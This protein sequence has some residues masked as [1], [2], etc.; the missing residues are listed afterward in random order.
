MSLLGLSWPRRD[1]ARPGD[2][3]VWLDLKAG[4]AGLPLRLGLSL[5]AAAVL[6]GLLML[7]LGMIEV[8]GS[9]H[10]VD[11]ATGL[12]LA[13]AAWCM[14]V[15]WLCSTYR[16]WRSA[17]QAI[18]IVA[19]IWFVTIPACVIIDQG[20]GNNPFLIASCIFLAIAATIAVIAVKAYRAAAGR[21]LEDRQ[22]AIAVTCACG[23]SMVGLESCQCPECG[24]AYTID[25]LIRQQ[26]Y[27][28][29][30]PG[31]NR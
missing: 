12:A 31:P 16:R 21:A 2:A 9:V 7:V 3:S 28:A 30:R 22:G 18:F 14:T 8:A 17:I 23:Y 15:A 10:D 6:L 26:D 25:G 1:A 24:T 13:G 4:R 27:A 19:G 29:L 11:V 5:A 20:V